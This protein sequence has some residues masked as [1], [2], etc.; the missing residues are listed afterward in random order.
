MRT[1]HAAV[2]QLRGRLWEETAGEPASDLR[3][4]L[5]LMG[6]GRAASL[7]T[8]MAERRAVLL[9]S[10]AGEEAAA[11][12]DEEELLAASP[13]SRLCEH[14]SELWGTAQESAA[15]RQ[16]LSFTASAACGGAVRGHALLAS[17]ATER[18][19]ISPYISPISPL[20]LPY[21]SPHLPRCR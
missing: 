10:R 14:L 4:E 11:T 2:A 6:P 20:Y 3:R 16:L 18:L 9:S 8:L 21:I 13:P 5:E 1:T 7:E 17:S 15:Q 19:P 12:R